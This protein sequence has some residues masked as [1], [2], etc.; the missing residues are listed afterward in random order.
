MNTSHIPHGDWLSVP[1]A[2]RAIDS[3]Y[4][5]AHFGKWGMGGTPEEVGYDVSD[6]PTKNV[7]GGFVNDRSQWE[8]EVVSD[9]KRVFELT[10]RAMAFM[11][12]CQSVSRPF[13]IQ[14]SHYAVHTNIEQH[15]LH[16]MKCRRR[17]L[18]SDIVTKEW[19]A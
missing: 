15:K 12:S 3:T 8:T 2:L 14:L 9:P 6:G 1:K 11:D 5:A 13:F 19:P 18:D 17:N 7:D 16:S 10:N 4:L